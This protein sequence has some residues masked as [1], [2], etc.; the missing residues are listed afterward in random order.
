M[1][2]DYKSHTR[3]TPKWDLKLVVNS[4]TRG[5]QKVEFLLPT[6]GF[7]GC[8]RFIWWRIDI[9]RRLKVEIYAKNSSFYFN[10]LSSSGLCAYSALDILDSRSVSLIQQQSSNSIAPHDYGAR[11]TFRALI[12]LRNRSS[13]GKC[14]VVRGFDEFYEL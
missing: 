5:V 10:P 11:W 6:G 8:E 1:H 7:C 13:E 9:F 12:D 14:D 2:L 3:F 4:S